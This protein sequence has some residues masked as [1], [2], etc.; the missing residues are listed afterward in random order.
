MS[1]EEKNMFYD[2]CLNIT[3]EKDGE[4]FKFV[5]YRHQLS[6]FKFF[7]NLFLISI[8]DAIINTKPIFQIVYNLTLPF[9]KKPIELVLKNTKNQNEIEILMVSCYFGMKNEKLVKL[10]KKLLQDKM[11]QNYLLQLVTCVNDLNFPFRDH[12]LARFYKQLDTKPDFQNI[13]VN[14]FDANQNE[15]KDNICYISGSIDS[16]QIFKHENLIFKTYTTVSFIDGEVT[17]GIW[18]TCNFMD[19][20][21]V[22]E[23]SERR[24]LNLGLSKVVVELFVFNCFDE[25]WISNC[26]T[27]GK[28]VL[29]PPPFDIQAYSYYN[30][31]RGRYGEVFFG[32]FCNETTAYRFEIQFI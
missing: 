19:E 16:N 6:K 32:D 27:K 17:H 23:F 9:T 20:P 8:P 24:M 15:Y 13:P 3:C 11:D 22:V 4:V 7:E 30:C 10:V 28:E 25:C 12:F 18:L 29:M 1:L 21:H 31:E 14:C 2:C 5:A 26:N